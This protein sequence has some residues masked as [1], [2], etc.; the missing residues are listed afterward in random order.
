MKRLILLLIIAIVWGIFCSVVFGE[1]VIYEKD[2]CMYIIG[3]LT[4]E[5]KADLEIYRKERMITRNTQIFN[6]IERIHEL[7][8][9]RIRAEAIIANADYLDYI[10]E[11]RD[12]AIAESG[13]TIVNNSNTVDVN[14][15]AEAY[16]GEAYVEEITNT[17]TN[18]NNNHNQNK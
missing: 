17:N 12:R 8:I 5:E 18:V 7:K 1:D 14:A 15:T 4:A 6:E 9:E 3:N 2:N 13:R 10:E 16:G 11:R